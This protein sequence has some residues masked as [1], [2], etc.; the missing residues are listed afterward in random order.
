M[1][2]R[3]LTVSPPT[4][5]PPSPTPRV[6]DA[7][8]A[9]EALGALAQAADRRVLRDVWAAWRTYVECMGRPELAHVAPRFPA[10]YVELGPASADGWRRL[11]D[12]ALATAR[13]VLAVDAERHWQ[14]AAVTFMQAAVNAAACAGLRVAS[15]LQEWQRHDWIDVDTADGVGA[16]ISEPEEEALASMAET[17]AHWGRVVLATA[18]VEG[19]YSSAWRSDQ[20]ARA[21]VDR[22]IDDV[23]RDVEL[24]ARRRSPA[25]VADDDVVTVC[26]V[27]EDVE[28]HDRE[29]PL[30]LLTAGRLLALYARALR[31]GAQ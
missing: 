30:A 10:V 29:C 22:A 4:L 6:L 21:A 13:N 2:A 5:S 12:L 31:G 7:V 11:L 14:E 25:F 1:Y 17:A 24:L 23:L 27:C 20:R 8:G 9:L 18:S 26:T 28:G 19:D 15:N 3:E 16:T